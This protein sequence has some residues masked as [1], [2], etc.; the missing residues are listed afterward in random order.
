MISGLVIRPMCTA[1]ITNIIGIEGEPPVWSEA[2][3]A[4]EIDQANG[5]QYVAISTALLGYICG[6]SVLDE[7]E[8]VKKLRLNMISVDREW[9][10][11]Y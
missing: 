2:Q 9:Q 1:D 6:R 8:I 4:G 7:A 11:D 3:F 10:H 5:W